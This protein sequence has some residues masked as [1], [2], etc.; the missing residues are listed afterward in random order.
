M[1][2]QIHIKS[3]HLLIIGGHCLNIVGIDKFMY[4][5]TSFML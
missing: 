1:Y 5:V 2:S 3:F 4:F